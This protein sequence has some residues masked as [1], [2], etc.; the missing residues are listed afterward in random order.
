MKQL[1][2][3]AFVLATAFAS[4]FIVLNLTGIITIEKIR[5]GMAEA[6]TAHGAL[7]C[8]L[9]ILLL[10]LDIIVAIPTLTVIILA[11]HFLGFGYGAVSA[12]SG[13]YLAGVTGYGV[14]RKYGTALLS[15]I[16]R[17][18]GKLQS[19]QQLFDQHGPVVLLLCRALPILPEV[20]CCLAG[21]NRMPFPRFLFYYSLASV[22]YACIAVYAG[23]K[24]SIDNL[25]PALFT[26][27]MLSLGLWLAWSIFLRK[28]YLKKFEKEQRQTSSLDT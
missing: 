22:P 17:D 20:T 14:S 28:F 25:T 5:W 24:S 26:A 19:M 23:S 16:Y 7:L 6:G 11:G 9:V 8:G 27:I 4:T 2:A 1:L 21:A 15:R 3:A 10:G 18:P 13:F 12:I